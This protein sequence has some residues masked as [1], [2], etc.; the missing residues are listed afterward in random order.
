M[1]LSFMLLPSIVLYCRRFHLKAIFDWFNK[2]FFRYLTK[3]AE[4]EKK[5]HKYKK[6]QKREK[7]QKNFKGKIGAQDMPTAYK[8]KEKVQC[9]HN[10]IWSSDSL[11]EAFAF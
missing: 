1:L 6:H 2:S 9:L 3:Y 5:V 11:K 10:K 8:K 7:L 4:W